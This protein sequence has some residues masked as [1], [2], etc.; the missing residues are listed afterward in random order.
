MTKD[1][2]TAR[3]IRLIAGIAAVSVIFGTARDTCALKM[4]VFEEPEQATYTVDTSRTTEISSLIF[5]INDN[6]DLEGVRPTALRQS[7]PAVSTYNWEINASNPGA[8]KG[9][10]NDV[11]LVDAYS[12]ASWRDP[13]LYTELLMSR[14][15]KY[16]IPHKYVTLQMMGYVAGDSLGVVTEDDS[17]SRWREV[18]FNKHDAYT[19]RPDGSDSKVYMDEYVSFIVD[20]YGTAD[21]GGADGYFLD[22]EPDKWTERFALT[23]VGTMD[24][25]KFVDRSAELA[26]TV[27]TIDSH[28]LVFGPSF[29]GL[30][31][32]I[33]AGSSRVWDRKFSGEWSWAIDYYLTG[34]KQ[35]SIDA[36]TRL[37]DVLDV[38]YF[39]EAQTPLGSDVLTHDDNYSNAYRMQAVRT[40]WDGDYAENSVNAL[41]NRQFTPFIPTLTSSIKINYAGT[42]LSFSEYDFGGGNNIS[43]AIAE[44]DTLGTFAREG[45]YMACLSPVTEDHRFQNAAIDIFN[46]ING[47]SRFGDTLYHTETED[48][49]GSCWAGTND[50]RDLTLIVTN[51]NMSA[52]KAVT[53]DIKGSEAYAVES[54]FTIDEEADIVEADT[55]H[56][57]IENDRLTFT[58]AP[59][60]V[61]LIKLSDTNEEI[62]E[63]PD[64][65]ETASVTDDTVSE[66]VTDDTAHAAPAADTSAERPADETAPPIEEVPETLTEKSVPETV[67]TAGTADSAQVTKLTEVTDV[68]VPPV[69]REAPLPLKVA[70]IGLSA[71]AFIGALYVLINDRKR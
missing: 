37:L 46:E 66:T 50:G 16:G 67:T 48:D 2:R 65:T 35:K 59:C 9:Y 25:G 1:I 34:M 60:S 43:G 49:M 14:C 29:S 63:D 7:D 51:Q 69:E 71:A 8:E 58:A 21:N 20:R 17:S 42:K 32:C 24:L 10:A 68:P 56:I 53:V 22:N 38:H 64:A 13:G 52:E 44:I 18:A 19:T 23:G 55:E 11:S 45:V 39:T 54:V 36:G 5:G 33:S 26:W 41:M 31:G 15:A 27:K 3:N 30:D 28:A 70:G 47:G 6:P 40:L 62:E 61:Y 12:S 57:T 4:A